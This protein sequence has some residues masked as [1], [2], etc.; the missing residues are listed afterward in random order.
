MTELPTQLFGITLPPAPAALQPVITPDLSQFYRPDEYAI[1]DLKAALKKMIEAEITDE[2]WA[3]KLPVREAAAVAEADFAIP[4]HAYAKLQKMA[5]FAAAQALA[6]QFSTSPHKPPQVTSF[7]AHPQ[8]FLNVSVSLPKL[9]ED[10]LQQVEKLGDRYGQQNIGEAK[11]VVIDSSSPN[12]AK[13]LTVGH[14]RPTVS[15]ESLGRLY[16]AGGYTV[17]RDNHL[18]DWGTQFGKIIRAYELWKDEIPEFASD[19]NSLKGLQKL[20]QRINTEI[21]NQKAAADAKGKTDRRDQNVDSELEEAG[22]DWFR[23]LEAGDP[24]AEKMWH[25][26]S[27]ISIK[28]LNTVYRELDSHFEYMI[29]ESQMVGMTS[30]I[31]QTLVN[32]GLA[33]PGKSGDSLVVEFPEETKIPAVLIRKSDGTSLYI[34][35]DIATLITRQAWF[36]PA[37]VIYPVGAEQALHFQQLFAIY[38]QLSG[39]ESLKLVY[40]PLGTVKINGGKMSSRKGNIIE[41]QTLI[42]TA[43][44]VAGAKL[45]DNLEKGR[46][47]ATSAETAE[48]IRQVAIGTT[49]YLDLKASRTRGINIQDLAQEV[50]FSGNTAA[51]LQYAAARA[52]KIGKTA[53][54]QNVKIDSELELPFTDSL[55]QLLVKKIG[56]YP[57]IV[58]EALDTNEPA[59]VSVYLFELASLFNRFY[60]DL[61]VLKES[62]EQLRNERLRLTA[63]V[64]QVIRNG[65]QILMIEVPEKM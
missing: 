64:A 30:E 42:D 56:L 8:G 26:V 31:N 17:I 50:D 3:S 44:E 58:A 27:E 51:Y 28:E 61:L 47:S 15:G 33:K 54:E 11:V 29:G 5:P 52:N 20:Y 9:G 16:Q 12:I 6:E 23:R 37:V 40:I 59:V 39:N 22:R 49:V 18:G 35:R 57:L 65:L 46:S 45:A 32:N 7:T 24:E 14:L 10:I 34:T 38:R 25:W 62:D 60:H 1:N 13:E 19:P 55:A 53:A 41:L 4:C 21:D 2:D 43:K 36:N 63:A 48:I